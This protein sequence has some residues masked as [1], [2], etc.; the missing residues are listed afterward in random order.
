MRTSSNVAQ[1]RRKTIYAINKSKEFKK[2]FYCVTSKKQ[3]ELMSK[4]DCYSMTKHYDKIWGNVGSMIIKF[5]SWEFCCSST[6]DCC[7]VYNERRFVLQ[8]IT[9]TA[10]DTIISEDSTTNTP[11]RIR[12]LQL[13]VSEQ[14]IYPM[15]K[16]A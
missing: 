13:V 3:L 10:R 9:L 5:T 14:L 11:N 7:I 16:L 6:S 2:L 8:T 1:F 15:K 12:A 4:D